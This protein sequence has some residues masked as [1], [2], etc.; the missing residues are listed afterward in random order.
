MSIARVYL[1]R[2]LL[3]LLICSFVSIC[4]SARPFTPFFRYFLPYICRTIPSSPTGVPLT[5]PRYS[6]A[7]RI[8]GHLD[9]VKDWAN[10]YNLGGFA[11][12]EVAGSNEHWHFHLE[13]ERT[14]KQLR[15]SFNRDIP[16]LKGN[17]AYSLTETKDKEKYLRYMCKGDSE[18]QMPE[19]SWTNSIL[20]NHTLVSNLHDEYW[21]ANRQ[22]K[23]RSG[24]VMDTVIDEAKRQRVPYSDRHALAK[25]Y[26]RVLGERGRP[27]NLFSLRA[28]LNAVQYALCP[29]DT[30]LNT[31]A[32]ACVIL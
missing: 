23:K 15:C 20:Y 27:I 9:K 32:D 14:I 12:R 28:S 7:L 1:K 13:G 29:D 26:I 30:Q 10:K 19:I 25:L 16:E 17:G 24:G 22:M 11:V 31:L 18:G 5:M 4:P 3:N 2:L 21:A 8:D 6:Y